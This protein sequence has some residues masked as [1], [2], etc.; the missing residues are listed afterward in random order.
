M[1]NYE[2]SELFIGKGNYEATADYLAAAG[3]VVPRNIG[4]Q[5]HLGRQALAARR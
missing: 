1:K 4:R 3:V 2:N 5:V